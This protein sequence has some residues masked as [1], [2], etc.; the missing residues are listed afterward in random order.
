MENNKIISELGLRHFGSKGWMTSKQVVCESCGRYDKCGIYFN[1]NGAVF[2]CM[3][4]DIKKPLNLYLKQTN[5]GHLCSNEVSVSNENKIRQ[6]TSITQEKEEIFEQLPIRKLPIGF[7]EIKS[8][9]YLD[10]RNFLDYHYNLFKPGITKLDLSRKHMIVFQIFDKDNRRVG[11]VARSRLS[12]DWHKQNL[13][14]NKENGEKIV[15]R[16]DNSTNTDFSCI[17]GGI[18]EIT[19]NTDTLIIVE[20]IFDKTNVDKELKLYD[21]EKIKCNFT[22]GNSIK[23]GQISILNNFPQIKLIYLLYDWGTI[24]NSKEYGLILEEQLKKEIR[25]CELNIKDTDPGELKEKQLLKI[26]QQ[27]VDP[28]S[29]K[30]R[31]LTN[32]VRR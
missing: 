17:I 27:S 2:N 12:K 31:K 19:E 21:N 8:D 32:V 6:I 20:G 22:F 29:Y 26:L 14:N 15:L 13:K 25:V 18:N 7:R 28:F 24:K 23:D 3:R 5:R 1:E 4:C 11:W 10:G 16:Y 9:D 30:Y